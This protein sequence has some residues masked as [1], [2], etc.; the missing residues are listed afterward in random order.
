MDTVMKV[1]VPPR[2]HIEMELLAPGWVNIYLDQIGSGAVSRRLLDHI[3]RLSME[4]VA[5]LNDRINN[6]MTSR[7]ADPTTVPDDISAIITA[8]MRWDRARDFEASPCAWC[9][10]FRPGRSGLCPEGHKIQNLGRIV[11]LRNCDTFNAR[12]DARNV[13]IVFLRHQYKECA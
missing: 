3:P 10:A 13:P 4:D 6:L 5:V 8:L 1:K 2:E 9:P 11:T 7:G 12:V